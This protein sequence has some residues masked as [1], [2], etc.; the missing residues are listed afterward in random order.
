MFDTSAEELVGYLAS[1]L[2]VASLAMS[3][4]VRL[5]ILSLIGS[6][7]FVVYGLLIESIPIIITNAAIAVI[8]IWFLWRE[9]APSARRG[10]DFGASR[11]RP[12][13]PF[14][15]D[16]VEYHQRDIDRFQ[17][18]FTMPEGD[19]VFSLVLM[20]DGLPTGL[21]IGRQRGSELRIDLDY[22]LAAHRDSRIAR[23]LFGP[24][25]DVFRDAGVDRLVTAATTVAHS[26]Y[27]ES[28]G[29]A[30]NA[31]VDRHVLTL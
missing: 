16:F 4:V 19:D 5:R 28:V 30:F 1:A 10:V 25:A 12:D 24:G 18:E 26:R 27:L 2:V 15:L 7:T 6:I 13:S 14:L 22:V 8:N 3:S 21:L 11:I 17:P 9:F 20:R 23:W 31:T 29:F